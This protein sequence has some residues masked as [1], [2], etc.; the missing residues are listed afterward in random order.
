[1]GGC[2]SS[3]KGVPTEPLTNG[4][5]MAANRRRLSLDAVNEP[6]N[7]VADDHD[8]NRGDLKKLT[9]KST[10]CFL[11][12]FLD[13]GILRFLGRGVFGEGIILRIKGFLRRKIKIIIRE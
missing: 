6:V 10:D 8:N 7:E 9:D 1:M 4:A 11:G 12:G 13:F 5:A 3:K 2:L